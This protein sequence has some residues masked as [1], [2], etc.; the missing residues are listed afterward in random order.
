MNPNNKQDA[1]GAPSW[2]PQPQPPQRSPPP[3]SASSQTPQQ[4][5]QQPHP[6]AEG[7]A[8]GAPGAARSIPSYA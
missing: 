4:Q 3:G 6:G 5:Q 1:P 8:H 7:L 2:Q